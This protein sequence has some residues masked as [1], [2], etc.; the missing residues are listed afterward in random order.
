MKDIQVNLNKTSATRLKLRHQVLM[1]KCSVPPSVGNSKLLQ[2][3]VL[4]VMIE[5][6]QPSL[7]LPEIYYFETFY[8]AFLSEPQQQYYLNL[9]KQLG[10]RYGDH[11]FQQVYQYHLKNKLQKPVNTL[12]QYLAQACQAY[13]SC[14]LYCTQ[15]LSGSFHDAGIY[16]ARALEFKAAPKG[17]MCYTYIN[18][19]R[20]E[21]D[22]IVD[23]LLKYIPGYFKLWNSFTHNVHTCSISNLEILVAM[24]K[25]LFKR[26][27]SSPLLIWL[28][29]VG[30]YLSAK[31]DLGDKV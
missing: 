30:H 20:Q 8:S 31:T 17:H 6:L 28:H 26:P 27:Q 9:V 24:V 25:D 1:E 13:T 19:S 5:K 3:Q 21:S 29:M 2:L 18:A 11:H 4:G 15:K 14:L 7:W 22:Q 10:M 23:I 12:Q 16:E